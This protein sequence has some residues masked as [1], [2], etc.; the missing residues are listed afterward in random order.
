MKGILI[1]LEGIDGAGNTTQAKLLSSWLKRKGF[2]VILTKEPTR[3][4]VGKLIRRRLKE[5]RVDAN[6]EALLF[7]ADRA[8]HVAKVIAPSLREGAIVVTDRYFESSIAY[9]GAQGA[10]VEWIEAINSFAPKP[11]L[12]VVLDLEPRLALSRKHERREVF[13]EENF[14][15]KVREILRRRA[16]EKGYVLVDASKSVKEVHVEVRKAVRHILKKLQS[17]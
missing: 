7:A 11:A 3:G 13:E 17:F 14:L 6:I 1:A 16:L 10:E 4:W 2:K 5:G 12:T 8:E 15:E 9:Q